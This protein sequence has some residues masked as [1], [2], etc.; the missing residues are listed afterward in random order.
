MAQAVEMSEADHADLERAVEL[1]EHPSFI[2]RITNLIG[3]P[4]E[5]VIDVLPSGAS[6]Q[7][8]GTV[9]SVLEKLLTISL[10]TLNPSRRGPAS[11]LEHTIGT[12][13]SGAVGGFFGAPALAVELPISTS[14]MLR[15][16]ADVARSEGENPRSPETRL[17][18][19]EVFALGG[20]A[21]GDNA[22]DTGYFAVRAALAKAMTDAARHLAERG[23]TREGA[24][25]LARLVAA[26]ASRFSTVVSEK[27]AVQSVPIL[28]AIGGA[29]INVLFARHFQNMARGHFTVR[30]LE[31]RHGSEPVRREYRRIA[32]RQSPPQAAGRLQSPSG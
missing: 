7:V 13:I 11:D 25:V 26:I 6:E 24:P 29:S 9:R 16:I 31:R 27:V 30:R 28:G 5:Q 18:C 15:S 14:I 32:E 2:G 17:A 8:Q 19:L 12:G 23:L 22:S 10:R 20:A 3:K 4:I 21:R 1:L